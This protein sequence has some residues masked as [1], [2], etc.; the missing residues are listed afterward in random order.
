[1]RLPSAGRAVWLGPGTVAL[2]VGRKLVKI[3]RPLLIGAIAGQ[4]C[5]TPAIT[6][7]TQVAQSSVPLLGDTI[8]Y[9]LCNFLRPLTGPPPH[10]HRRRRETG[11]PEGEL[12]PDALSLSDADVS[13]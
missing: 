2:V 8:T 12:P 5:S 6:C 4:Q 11:R 3:G 10:G 1:A 9:T 7:I 13:G